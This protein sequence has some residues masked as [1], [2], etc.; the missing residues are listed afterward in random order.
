MKTRSEDPLQTPPA[1]RRTLYVQ[2]YSP[3]AFDLIGEKGGYNEI[4]P[5]YGEGAIPNFDELQAG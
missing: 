3:R 1:R 2:H 5:G 4:M